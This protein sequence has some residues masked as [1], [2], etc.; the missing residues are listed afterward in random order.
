MKAVI[1]TASILVVITV[2]VALGVFVGLIP[3]ILTQLKRSST[4][5]EIDL[6]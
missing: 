6:H 1:L 4:R 3:W 2:I 5:I